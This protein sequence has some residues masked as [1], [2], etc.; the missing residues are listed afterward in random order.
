MLTEAA[1]SRRDTFRRKEREFCCSEEEESEM[2]ISHSPREQQPRPYTGAK[3]ISRC[4][5]N[6]SLRSTWGVLGAT[7]MAW[8]LPT[9]QHLCSMA[10]MP[11]RPGASGSGQGL[12]G[13]RMPP[14]AS[15]KTLGAPQG[16]AGPIRFPLLVASSRQT[17][18]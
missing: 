15:S 3:E 18:R 2:V 6:S 5:S 11:K 8:D 12:G 13:T 14:A 1:P 16:T 7:S 17:P 9:T 10:L 4:M